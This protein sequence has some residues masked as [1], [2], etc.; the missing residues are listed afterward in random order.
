MA[1]VLEKDWYLSS[2]ADT[3]LDVITVVLEKSFNTCPINSPAEA[4]NAMLVVEENFINLSSTPVVLDVME[5]VDWNRVSP[6][7][8]ATAETSDVMTAVLDK[9]IIS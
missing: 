3:A 1:V 2:V 7:F 4:S 6:V 8:K 5:A 9:P